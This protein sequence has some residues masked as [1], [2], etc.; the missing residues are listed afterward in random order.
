MYMDVFPHVIF[1]LIPPDT[2][3]FLIP[4]KAPKQLTELSLTRLL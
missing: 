4:G 1:A 3:I 2:T